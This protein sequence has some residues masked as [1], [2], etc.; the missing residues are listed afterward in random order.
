MPIQV[1]GNGLCADRPTKYIVTQLAVDQCLAVVSAA[2]L[3]KRFKAARACEAQGRPGRTITF[4]KDVQIA[5]CIA[6]NLIER[7]AHLRS[8]ASCETSLIPGAIGSVEIYAAYS[9]PG[10]CRSQAA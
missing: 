10:R 2:K 4:Q 6:W 1:V 3:R 5:G 7:N 9:W 8:H